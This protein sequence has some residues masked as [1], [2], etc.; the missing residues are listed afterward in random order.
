MVKIRRFFK[1]IRR[2]VEFLPIIWKGRDFDYRYA[3]DLFQFQLKRLGK[4]ID[5]NGGFVGYGNT[6]NRINTAI[7]LIDKVYDGDYELEGIN[8]FEELYGKTKF[9]FKEIDEVDSNGEKFYEIELKNNPIGLIGVTN[10][11][12]CVIR[13]QMIREAREKHIRAEDILWRFISHN[14]KGWWD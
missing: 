9:E 3:L 7:E 1:Q 6:T 11:E 8:K 14:I 12:L 2:V 4:E 5:N 13:D 10:D